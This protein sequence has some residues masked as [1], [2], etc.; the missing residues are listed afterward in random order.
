[1]NQGC[2]GACA[3]ITA[4]QLCV[5]YIYVEVL[6]LTALHVEIQRAVVSTVLQARI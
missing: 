4:S 2:L 6:S 5:G 3:S 1:M